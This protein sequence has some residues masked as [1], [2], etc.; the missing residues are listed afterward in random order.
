MLERRQIMRPVRLVETA[1]ALKLRVLPVAVGEKVFPDAAL[2]RQRPKP[3]LAPVLLPRD[4][5]VDGAHVKLGPPYPVYPAVARQDMVALRAAEGV[6]E[7]DVEFA[8]LLVAR[9]G[10]DVAVVLDVGRAG[11]E[12]PGIPL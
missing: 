7:I 6:A 1:A 3:Y 8:P 2:A 5:A 4:G 11:E 9:P 12:E 10:V